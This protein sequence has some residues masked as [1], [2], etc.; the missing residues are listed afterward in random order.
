M[1]DVVTAQS[2]LP[3][4]LQG[5]VGTEVFDEFAGGVQSGFPVISYRG[6]VWRVRKGGE[7]QMHVD[8]DNNALPTIEVI[9]LRSNERP[10]KT[11]Y[12]SGYTEGDQAKPRC[13]SSDGIK[14]DSGVPMPVSA[15]CA[16]CPMN[17]W[18]SKTTEQGKPS[19]ACQDV[20][21]CAVAMLYQLE[22]VAAGTRAQDDVDILLLRV[23]PASLNPLKDYAETVLKPKGIPPYVLST[24]IGFNAEVA[25]PQ[26]TFK[27]SRF[28]NEVEFEVASALRTS[29]EAKRVLNESLELDGAGTTEGQDQVAG[30]GQP[31]ADVAPSAPAPAAKPAKKAAK[32]KPQPVAEDEPPR[33]ADIEAAAAQ[34]E[35]VDDIAAAPPPS[36]EPV[37]AA[38][39]AVKPAPAGADFEDMLDSILG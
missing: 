22:E 38:P 10:S 14:P 9:L 37:T 24:K 36:P 7:E 2:Q 6:K 30:A 32:P 1:N 26:F 8:A 31:Q 25:Y 21:R 12:D 39:P 15:M 13:W 18:G 28:L 34:A 20:R 4:H 19:R 3:A 16:P 23:P 17:V 33:A 27:G 5:V 11:H 35:T 29:D